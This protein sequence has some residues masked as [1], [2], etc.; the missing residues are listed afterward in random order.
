M[1]A[2]GVEDLIGGEILCLEAGFVSKGCVMETRERGGGKV[3]TGSVLVVAL[4][5]LALFTALAVAIAASSDINMIIARNRGESRQAAAFAE[6]GLLLL[7]RHLGG[8]AVTPTFQVED[9]HGAIASHL[10]TAWS[11][12][13][14]IEHAA[15]IWADAAGVHFPAITIVRDD[16]RSGAVDVFL[17]ADGGAAAKPIITIESTGRFGKAARNVSYRMTTVDSWTLLSR[18]GIAS[19]SNIQMSG[20]AQVVGANEPKEGSILSATYV[21]MEA[22][23]LTG[24]VYV[25]GDVAVSNPQATILKTGKVRIDGSEVYGAEEVSWPTPNPALFRPYA[26]NVIT[27]PPASAPSSRAVSRRSTGRWWRAVLN[28]PAMPEELFAAPW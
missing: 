8:L 3:V 7:G 19:R 11:D 22:I 1:E 24:G 15:G 23:T 21:E 17:S 28:F 6:T 26:T 12:S 10:V 2:G 18:Y 13:S 9:L 14:M 16:G 20:N 27:S 25:S 5:F 4:V